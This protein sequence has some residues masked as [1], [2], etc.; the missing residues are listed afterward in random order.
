MS[1]V[2]IWVL[3][4]PREEIASVDNRL[5][6]LGILAS[7][8]PQ[9]MSIGSFQARTKS[10]INSVSVEELASD[11]S[12]LPIVFEIVQTGK[13]GAIYLN[14]PGLGL[15]RIALDLAGEPVIRVGQ[16]ESFLEVSGGNMSELKR[17]IRIAS[18]TMWFDLLE[19]Y[20]HGW[21]NLEQFPKA[22]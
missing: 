2:D 3:S 15:K 5:A 18:G 7:W 22:V 19:P 21:G 1:A 12:R 9:P 10:A 11:L 8:F 16:L 17:L 4:A 14:H 20:R 6:S 13:E